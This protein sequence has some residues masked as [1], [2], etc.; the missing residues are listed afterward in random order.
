MTQMTATTSNTAAT[1]NYTLSLNDLTAWTNIIGMQTQTGLSTTYNNAACAAFTNWVYFFT[2]NKVVKEDIPGAWGI[3]PI[4][5][6]YSLITNAGLLKWANDLFT[7]LLQLQ[8][9]AFSLHYYE[10]FTA[11][12]RQYLFNEPQNLQPVDVA[13]WGTAM[14]A[15]SSKWGTYFPSN[16]ERLN[17]TNADTWS[18][19]PQL[20][21]TISI[22]WNDQSDALKTLN[23]LSELTSEQCIYLM[24]LLP[25]LVSGTA[26]QQNSVQKIVT[27][28]CDSIE[29]PNSNFCTSLVYYNLMLLADPMGNYCQ[30]NP[31]IQNIINS[32]S[33][34][35]TGTDPASVAMKAALSTQAKIMSVSANYPMVDPYNS[36][37]GLTTRQSD[38]LEGINMTWAGLQSSM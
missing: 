25:S 22:L 14:L 31:Q 7:Q 10:I 38:M 28:P 26:N 15:I 19:P 3:H 37:T 21:S 16:L 17:L 11:Y 12:A 24:Y 35:I 5:P 23:Q 8:V 34:T 1:T 29:L 30:T 9:P 2:M 4:T 20:Q 33:A 18:N 36:G 13:G 27:A 6:V 32:L